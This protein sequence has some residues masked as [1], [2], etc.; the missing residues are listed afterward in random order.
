MAS[1]VPCRHFD[2]WSAELCCNNSVATTAGA[3]EKPAVRAMAN[4]T[5]HRGSGVVVLIKF[6]G[7]AVFQKL[8]W[9]LHQIARTGRAEETRWQVGGAWTFSFSAAWQAWSPGFV[10]RA[11]SRADT[12]GTI[13]PGGGHRNTARILQAKSTN[14][15]YSI[16]RTDCLVA[17]SNGGTKTR[18]TN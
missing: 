2:P 9:V 15:S 6:S 16:H 5:G 3:T 14:Q 7:W 18:H 11:S 17:G 8:L 4:N 13:R 12:T 10:L 1:V